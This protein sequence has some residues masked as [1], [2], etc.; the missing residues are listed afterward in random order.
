[1]K[2]VNLVPH[3]VNIVGIDKEVTTIDAS[4]CVARVHFDLKQ[5]G[6]INNNI[7]VYKKE[8]Q[9]IDFGTIIL[10]YT[11]YI[12]SGEVMKALIECNHPQ[13][14]QFACPNTTRAT[15]DDNGAIISVQGLIIY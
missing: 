7:V 5:H 4:G 1:M 3:K 8:Y 2:I 9:D 14:H 10:P 12:V 13:I 15:K 6:I 11:L